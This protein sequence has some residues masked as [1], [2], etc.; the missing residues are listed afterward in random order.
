MISTKRS[1]YSIGLLTT[2]NR[3]KWADIRHELC[4]NTENAQNL[5]KI[6]SSMFLVCLDE[7]SPVTRE[8]V[9]RQLWHGNGNDRFFD[10]SLQFIVFAN[11]KAGFNGEHSMMDGIPTSRICE[12]ILEGYHF[13]NED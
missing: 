10:K 11:G 6:E 8:N 7:N 13:S 2:E 9:G 12:Y 3:D 1:K 5:E 4:Q